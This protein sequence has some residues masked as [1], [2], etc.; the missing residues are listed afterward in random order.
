MQEKPETEPIQQAETPA[1]FESIAEVVEKVECPEI[2]TADDDQTTSAE[3]TITIAPVEAFFEVE[4]K[5]V[6]EEESFA[7]APD[8][9]PVETSETVFEMKEISG[10][11]EIM[12]TQA[13]EV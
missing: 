9:H 12:E 2:I 5:Q 11:S 10:P 8:A 13:I 7:H 6:E 1:D 3:E 4:T